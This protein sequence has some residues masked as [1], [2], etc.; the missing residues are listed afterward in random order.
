MTDA[1]AFHRARRAASYRALQRRAERFASRFDPARPTIL[2]VPGLTGSQLDR[3]SLPFHE[4]AGVDPEYDPVWLDMGAVLSDIRR[5]E[6]TDDGEDLDRHLVIPNGPLRFFFSPYDE[7]ARFFLRARFNVAVFSYDWRRPLDEAAE[8]LEL[9]VELLAAAVMERRGSAHDPRPR[10]TL[11]CHSMGGLVALLLLQRLGQRLQSHPAAI[12]DWMHC[13][14]TVG[15]PFY[16]TG[17]SLQSYY[18][19]LPY[20]N[21]CYGA[22]AITRVIGSF[23]GPPVAHFLDR[24]SY[25]EYVDAFAERKEQPE[26][27]SYPCRDAAGPDGECDPF[28]AQTFCRYPA[29]K[30]KAHLEGALAL[31][32]RLHRRLPDAFLSR[33]FHI[34]VPSYETC[35]ELRWQTVDGSAYSPGMPVPLAVRTGPGDGVVPY[36]SAR[37]C[38]SPGT[39][40]WDVDARTDHTFLMEDEAVLGG[41]HHIATTRSLPSRE[42]RNTAPSRRP[43]MAAREYAQRVFTRAG[44][45][46]IA[47]GARVLRRRSLWRRVFCDILLG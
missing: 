1:S 2:L 28:D 27:L 16:G 36:W 19:G 7:L 33:L 17:A 31:R 5:L 35:C 37:Y 45:G 15:T 32:R 46:R 13:I 14:V 41:L 8:F 18:T 34:R 42:G 38:F 6:I 12:A 44:E 43:E 23:P 39:Q 11:A 20:F 22:A 40:V 25:R 4:D 24:E 9:F 3:S 21:E 29:W 30:R 10:L 26:L 47:P